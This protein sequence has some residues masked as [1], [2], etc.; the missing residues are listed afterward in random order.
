MIDENKQS[1]VIFLHIFSIFLITSQPLHI[2][3]LLELFD[4]E[5]YYFRPNHFFPMVVLFTDFN[6]VFQI[7]TKTC[8][9]Q[10]FITR[11]CQLIVLIV[12]NSKKIFGRKL[13]F[14][15]TLMQ[16]NNGDLLIRLNA[17]RNVRKSL[18]PPIWIL[19]FL[20]QKFLGSF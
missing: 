16:Q 10:V 2:S 18:C 3:E 14:F 15:T 11:S 7:P 8:K 13:N 1:F 6:M 5:L 9:Q 17:N 4:Y 12:Q 19:K 20:S